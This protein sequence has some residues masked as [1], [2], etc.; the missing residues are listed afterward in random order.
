MLLKQIGLFTSPIIFIA[1]FVWGVAGGGGGAGALMF[2]SLV[3]GVW[4]FFIRKFF[5]KGESKDFTV[6]D[7][8]RRRHLRLF[9]PD[10]L[11]AKKLDSEIRSGLEN[12]KATLVE[13]RQLPADE[14]IN[15]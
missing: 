6:R 9:A 3:F 15:L 10:A 13:T 1:G 14:V 11:S 12:L 2:F 5:S 7:L 4:A 8:M